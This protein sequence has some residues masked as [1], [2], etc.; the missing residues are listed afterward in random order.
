MSQD[1]GTDEPEHFI[2]RDKDIE[3]DDDGL[4][5]HLAPDFSVVFRW[6]EIQRISLSKLNAVAFVVTHLTIESDHERVAV[7]SKTSGYQELV[8]VLDQRLGMTHP[9]WP[10]ILRRH[11]VGPFSVP[12]YERA[13][14]SPHPEEHN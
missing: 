4:T 9:E 13:P 3:F 6:D 12:V 10:K 2:Q 1:E 7:G 14:L 5:V 11:P 8:D